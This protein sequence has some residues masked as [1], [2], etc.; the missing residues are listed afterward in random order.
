[1]FN[2]LKYLQSLSNHLTDYFLHIP[3]LIIMIALCSLLSATPALAETLTVDVFTDNANDGSCDD[4][5]CSLRDAITVAASGDTINFAALP[6]GS[7]IT[8]NGRQLSINKNLNIITTLPITISGAG[9]SRIFQIPKGVELFIDSLSLRNGSAPEGGA[10]LNRGKL[11]ITNSMLLGNKAGIGG[12]IRS[13]KSVLSIANSTLADNTASHGGAI[14]SSDSRLTITNSTLSGNTASTTDFGG[15][16]IRNFGGTLTITGSTLSHNTAHEGGAIYN[17]AGK[18]TITSSTLSGNKAHSEGGAIR[19]PGGSVVTVTNSTLSGN[20]AKH[21][22]AVSSYKGKLTFTNSKLSGNTAENGGAIYH[23]AGTLA[24]RQTI[25]ANNNGGDCSS[26]ITSAEY[27]ASSDGTCFNTS[28]M[29]KRHDTD[30][31]TTP[32][33]NRGPGALM[34]S[35]ATH[36]QIRRN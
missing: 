25:I 13:Y 17:Y 7:T 11:V 5:N 30:S 35:V 27:N 22:G 2:K 8:L 32:S 6:G 33:G 26:P 19:I 15:G 24:I 16:A 36:Q 14:L 29:D 1:M 28:M 3:P 9:K 18:L 4:G 20:T 34:L 23:S 21:G 12:A 10:I 31:R